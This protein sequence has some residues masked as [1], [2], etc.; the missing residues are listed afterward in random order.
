MGLYWISRW[1][2]NFR[3][4]V[5]GN[6][7]FRREGGSLSWPKFTVWPCVFYR[8][9][10]SP[11]LFIVALHGKRMPLLMHGQYKSHTQPCQPTSTASLMYCFA[12]CFLCVTWIKVR[13]LPI[14]C[15][16]Q[17][18]ADGRKPRSS[19]ILWYICT[20]SPGKESGA[21]KVGGSA[22]YWRYF[23]SLSAVYNHES[24]AKSV[25]K[26]LGSTNVGIVVTSGVRTDSS[27]GRKSLLEKL[28]AAKLL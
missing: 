12:I 7:L 21:I 25:K 6:F 2:S 24:L 22:K 23:T 15:L 14:R 10:D 16:T 20:M 8:N 27:A 11:L 17:W 3:W 28:M 18:M 4:H 1:K 5:V 9:A 19:W 26:P 13:T